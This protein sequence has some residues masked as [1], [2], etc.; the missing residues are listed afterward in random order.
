MRFDDV[1]YITHYHKTGEYPKI[2]DDI[3]S[4]DKY[5]PVGNVMDLGCCTGLLSNRLAA[6]HNLVVGIEANKKYLDNAVQKSNVHYY[7]TKI[8]Q[9]TLSDIE[10]LVKK[11]KINVV[12]ARR[13]L[14]EICDAGGVTLVQDLL[15][16]FRE[17]GVEYIVIEGRKCNSKSTHIL[18][19]VEQEK[20]L[21]SGLYK[22]SHTHNQCAIFAK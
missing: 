15:R 17:N 3:F 13:V 19:S 21:F 11:H 9:E 8:T 5:V 2:H 16:M 12:Y 6:K 1:E 4:M 20:L 10:K 18:K 7:N 22:C 14:P